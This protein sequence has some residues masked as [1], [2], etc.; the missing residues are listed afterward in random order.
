MNRWQDLA[1]Q[2]DAM[3]QMRDDAV[4]AAGLACILAWFL[5]NFAGRLWRRSTFNADGPGGAG[6]ATP[7]NTFVGECP[8]ENEETG[9]A[10]GGSLESNPGPASAN[11]AE[12][13][14]TC[15]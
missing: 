6:D 14:E 11:R 10:C 15:N 7:P 13:T 12:R 2:S 9:P 8:P 4:T 5:W 3:Q 1:A